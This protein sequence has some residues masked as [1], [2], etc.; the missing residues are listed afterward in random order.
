MTPMSKV[1]SRMR[2]SLAVAIV[3]VTLVVLGTAAWAVWVPVLTT[4]PAVPAVPASVVVALRAVESTAWNV[5]LWQPFTDVPVA[6]ATVAVPVKLCSIL[7]RDGIYI[8]ALDGGEGAGMI[9]AHTGDVVHGVTIRAI[10]ATGVD[11]HTDDGDRRVE[12]GR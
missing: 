12:L 6:S 3:G 8:A 1:A 5:R 7:R 9:F 2:R 11:L 10:D 4:A